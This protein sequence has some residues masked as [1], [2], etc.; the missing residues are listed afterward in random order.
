MKSLFEQMGGTYCQEG[1]QLIPNLVLPD[2]DNYCTDGTCIY[3]I[4]CP[5]SAIWLITGIFRFI[6]LLSL[7]W[8]QDDQN[9]SDTDGPG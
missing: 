6:N 1:D 5:L 2:T 4:E 7:Y 8:L 9:H 3:L